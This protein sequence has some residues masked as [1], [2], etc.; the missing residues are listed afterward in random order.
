MLQK[1]WKLTCTDLV[2]TNQPAL[3]QNSTVLET[4]LSDFYLFIVFKLNLNWVFKNA[5]PTLLLIGS[6]K[7]MTMMLLDLKFKAFIL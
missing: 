7:T 6:I 3:S 5:S 2:L 4:G 1:L